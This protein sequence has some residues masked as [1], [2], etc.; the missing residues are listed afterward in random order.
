[1]L[2][3]TS[4][5]SIKFLGPSVLTKK[6]VLGTL[7]NSASCS[8]YFFVKHADWIKNWGVKRAFL[9]PSLIDQYVIFRILITNGRKPPALR[10]IIP[11]VNITQ[12]AQTISIILS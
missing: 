12:V 6:R 4:L 9:N 2:G 11:K 5:R 1:M 8:S 10:I 7:S 3:I